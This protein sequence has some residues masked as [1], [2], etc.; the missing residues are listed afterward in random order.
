MPVRQA[1]GLDRAL[2]LAALGNSPPAPSWAANHN[3]TTHD[4]FHR[5]ERAMPHPSSVPF[6]ARSSGAAPRS[7][8]VGKRHKKRA[9]LSKGHSHPASCPRLPRTCLPTTPAR[10]T[11]AHSPPSSASP[12]A[13]AFCL[14]CRPLH[15]FDVFVRSGRPLSLNSGL[16]RVSPSNFDLLT[17][18]VCFS[19][20]SC[21]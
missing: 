4:F 11:R 8:P 13:I 1:R 5:E 17:N 19:F 15:S 9:G 3:N 21:S 10:Y 16:I 12:C 7:S 6:I 18:P 2:S 20:V 14:G